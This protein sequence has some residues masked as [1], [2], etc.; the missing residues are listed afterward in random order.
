[1]KVNPRRSML[2]PTV[3]LVLVILSLSLAMPSQP[4]LAARPPTP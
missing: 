1:M 2:T 3:L 4:T